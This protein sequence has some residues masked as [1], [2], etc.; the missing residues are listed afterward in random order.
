MLGVLD[1]SAAQG[2]QASFTTMPGRCSKGVKNACEVGHEAC[3]A[4]SEVPDP[5]AWCSHSFSSRFVEKSPDCS[6][7]WAPDVRSQ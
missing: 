2:Y 7:R 4:L 6:N 3:N 5:G 1:V